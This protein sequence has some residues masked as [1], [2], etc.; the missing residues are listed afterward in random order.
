MIENF[1]TP[2]I[3]IT[4]K[5][6]T[7]DKAY[8]VNNENVSYEIWFEED[9][10]IY[11]IQIGGYKYIIVTMMGY[12]NIY[13]MVERTEDEQF[14]DQPAITHVGDSK[15]TSIQ[16][17]NETI[18][19]ACTLSNT[20]VAGWTDEAYP[21]RHNHYIVTVEFKGKRLS[22]D[23]FDSRNNFENGVVDK[24]RKELIEMFFCFLNDITTKQEYVDKWEFMKVGSASI[25]KALCDAEKRYNRVFEG[26]ELYELYNRLQ[27][28]YNI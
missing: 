1:Q 6:Q 25:W 11:T 2:N 8:F 21:E 3:Y 18:R 13:R 12:C 14:D 9:S 16:F 5:Y 7:I 26:V 23:Y 28:I 15:E 19:I 10:K 24:D 20:K 17:E 22:F 27:E 4:K